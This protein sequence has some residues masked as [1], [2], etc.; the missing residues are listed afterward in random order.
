MQRRYD[1]IKQVIRQSI[2][3]RDDLAKFDRF[4][5][6]SMKP[7]TEIQSTNIYDQV[8]DKFASG[9]CTSRDAEELREAV[10]KLQV[11]LKL[12]IA[13]LESIEG[14]IASDLRDFL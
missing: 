2:D 3:V 5:A 10:D 1:T 8:I 7:L 11:Q 14:K 6:D 12:S 4:L 13:K 9:Q